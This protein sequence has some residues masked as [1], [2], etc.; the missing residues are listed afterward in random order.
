M[1]SWYKKNNV[2]VPVP[3]NLLSTR[4]PRSFHRKQP[5]TNVDKNARH[6]HSQN[7]IEEILATTHRTERE[8]KSSLKKLRQIILDEGLPEE[9]LPK[10]DPSV[11]S[12]IRPIS[13][14]SRVWKHFLGVYHVSMAEYVRLIKKGRS[15]VYDKVR[16]DTFRTMATDQRFLQRV[17]EDMLIRVLNAFAW[18]LKFSGNTNIPYVQGMNVLVAPFL[19]TMSELDAFFSF[20]AFIQTCCP[21][22][23][24][25]TLQGV[26]CGLKLLDKCLQILDPVLYDHLESKNLNAKIYA[27]PMVLTFCACKPPLDQVLQL[28]D[29]LFAFGVHVN[30][31]C[32]IAQLTMMRDKLLEST[33]PMQLLNLRAWPEL[34]AKAVIDKTLAQIQLIPDKLY[35]QLVRHP[36]DPSV[37]I[38][39]NKEENGQ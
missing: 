31:I 6:Q 10:L 34:Q 37:T 21:L 25:P 14:R 27:F 7:S 18:K 2:I 30:I 12:L 32:V 22:Y 15:C 23:V 26:H 35:D 17:N 24:T 16:N 29:F 4:K 19:F 3:V 28:W 39:L 20:A 11:Q 9:N 13:L 33:S 36:F 38:E 5:T 8:V 1:N